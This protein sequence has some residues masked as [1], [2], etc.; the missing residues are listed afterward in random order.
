MLIVYYAIVYYN[1]VSGRRIE[2]PIGSTG[3][4]VD[5][6]NFFIFRAFPWFSLGIWIKKYECVLKRLYHWSSNSLPYAVCL[7]LG[8]LLTGLELYWLGDTPIYFGTFLIIITLFA[9]AARERCAETDRTVDKTRTIPIYL[10][11]LVSEFG[12][13]LS[14]GVYLLHGAA[15]DAVKIV[16]MYVFSTRETVWFSW[17][18][19]VL[20][21]VLSITSAW[22]LNLLLSAM[23]RRHR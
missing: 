14:L 5:L 9:A 7:T 10:R 18:A 3:E 16:Q 2:F 19:P 13:E 4:T 17:I 23:K 12:R 20:V 6:R 11:N 8:A 21:I 15:I 22:T 1:A